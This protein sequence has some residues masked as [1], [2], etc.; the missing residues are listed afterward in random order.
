MSKIIL[1]INLVLSSVVF[2]WISVAYFEHEK[3]SNK[4]IV[5][6][7]IDLTYF[8]IPPSFT[9]EQIQFNASYFVN[10]DTIF[11]PKLFYLSLPP[12][13]EL[14]HNLLQLNLAAAT[15]KITIENQ[16]ISLRAIDLFSPTAPLIGQRFRGN[17]QS[18][19]TSRATQFSVNIDPPIHV[20]LSNF[21]PE[22]MLSSQIPD[23]NQLNASAPVTPVAEFPNTKLIKRTYKS[24][25]ISSKR[26]LFKRIKVQ[27]FRSQ[28]PA[29]QVIVRP[30]LEDAEDRFQTQIKIYERM[31]SRSFH[32]KQTP[33]GKQT[34]FHNV[35]DPNH[36]YFIAIGV[37]AQP[38]NLDK[39]I[40]KILSHNLPVTVANS[41]P[42]NPRLRQLATGPFIHKA[43]AIEVLN[44]IKALGYSDAYLQKVK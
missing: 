28:L 7:G 17:A 29:P 12:V 21:D 32:S 42:G 27:N 37:F 40:N 1:F 39:N 11:A 3:Q 41:L 33:I 30:S 8:P 13:S 38:S 44:A 9:A 5:I 22:T 36:K 10:A 4:N 34:K 16:N 23:P 6:P 2:A 26:P 31:L 25:A 20:R 14:S 18:L 19:K 15:S 43:K 35:K 24:E